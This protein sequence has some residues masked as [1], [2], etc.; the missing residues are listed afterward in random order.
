MYQDIARVSSILP[1]LFG[2]LM[3]LVE[4]CKEDTTLMERSIWMCASS[5]IRLLGVGQPAGTPSPSISQTKEQPVPNLFLE[6]AYYE[7]NM[8]ELCKKFSGEVI[9]I[10]DTGGP[11]G[12]VVHSVHEDHDAA[13]EEAKRIGVPVLIQ[14]VP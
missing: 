3:I 4:H 9:T 7:A 11:L 1:P 12:I 10:L 6:H 14:Q 5:T 8:D 13:C 2:R